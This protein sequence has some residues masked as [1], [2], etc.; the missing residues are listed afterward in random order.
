MRWDRDGTGEG[1]RVSAFREKVIF[2]GF[3]K[4]RA[5]VEKGGRLENQNKHNNKAGALVAFACVEKL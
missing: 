2:V 5:G 3:G 4:A 1:R